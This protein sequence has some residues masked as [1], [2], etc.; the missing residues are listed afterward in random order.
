MTDNDR[1][2][3]EIKINDLR[4][5][6]NDIIQDIENLKL[7]LTD[8]NLYFLRNEIT[9]NDGIDNQFELLENNDDDYKDV[10][11]FAYDT[12]NNNIKYEIDASPFYSI[13]YF[14]IRLNDVEIGSFRIEKK[15]MSFKRFIEYAVKPFIQDA[16]Y[17]VK[18]INEECE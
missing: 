14:T 5:R 7:K 8:E 16:K 2:D 10:I 18:I 11:Y 13:W 9:D 4:I 1:K 6:K 3:I 12:I 15:I 17:D